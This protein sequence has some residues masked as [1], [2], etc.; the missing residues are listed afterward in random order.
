ME[1]GASRAVHTG[2]GWYAAQA[3]S[4][5]RASLGA[6]VY[7]S[8]RREAAAATSTLRPFAEKEHVLPG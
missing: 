6:V 4:F 7:A 5:L 3:N 8:R 1:L 2:S